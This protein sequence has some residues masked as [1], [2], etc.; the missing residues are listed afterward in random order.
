MRRETYTDN[1]LV[2]T[3]EAEGTEWVIKN[4]QGVETGREPLTPEELAR[5]QAEG[6]PTPDEA[7]VT[8]I[9]AASTVAD[10]K[11]ALVKRFGG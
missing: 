8:D 1:K 11:A 4:A 6:Q 2:E 10:I 9:N 3:R 7:L 5:F